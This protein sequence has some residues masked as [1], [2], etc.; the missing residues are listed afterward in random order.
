[1]T[2]F[3]LAPHYGYAAQLAPWCR[4]Q[5]LPF[6]LIAL[7]PVIFQSVGVQVQSRLPTHLDSCSARESP[8]KFDGTTIAHT[9]GTG[10][11]TTCESARGGLSI[12]TTYVC[13]YAPPTVASV[14]A[15][16]ISSV[17]SAFSSTL[18]SF[19]LH[20]AKAEAASH[21]DREIDKAYAGHEAGSYFGNAHRGNNTNRVLAP[22][23]CAMLTR[24]T[25]V[26]RC[27]SS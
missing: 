4:A 20:S 17:S 22:K 23:V 13:W 18:S 19:R 26:C 6:D 5:R 2:L 15:T 25:C 16:A 24:C 11:G 14:T 27:D 3:L 10:C 9:E 12:T 21:G 7:K 1:M 8:T